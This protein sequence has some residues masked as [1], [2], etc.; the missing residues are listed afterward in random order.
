[1]AVSLPLAWRLYRPSAWTDDAKRCTA[2]GVPQT[3]GFATQG[4][5]AWEQIEA[6]LA[7]GIPKGIML[8]DAG[9]GDEAAFGDQPQECGLSTPWVSARRP[10]SGGGSINPP[11]RQRTREGGCACA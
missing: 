10:S 9:Y 4:A 11:L 2:A 6:A 5:L 8:A 1:M 7:A 3:V